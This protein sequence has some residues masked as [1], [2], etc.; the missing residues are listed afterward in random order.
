MNLKIDVFI[1]YLSYIIELFSMLILKYSQNVLSVD[2]V[3]RNTEIIL[4]NNEASL[5]FYIG[6]AVL[7]IFNIL[8][9]L[10]VLIMFYTYKKDRNINLVSNNLLLIVL[11]IIDFSLRFFD[12]KRMIRNSDSLRFVIICLLTNLVVYIKYKKNNIKIK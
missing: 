1:I 8:T 6:Y 7:L 5:C 9:I 3:E 2:S 11:L 12:V 10:Y 4:K